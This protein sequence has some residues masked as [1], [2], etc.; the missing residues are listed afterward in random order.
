MEIPHREG[1]EF[2]VESPPRL[3]W[4]YCDTLFETVIPDRTTEF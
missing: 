3:L 1:A 2:E 4:E